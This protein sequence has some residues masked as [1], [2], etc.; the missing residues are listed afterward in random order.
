M[1]DEVS[2]NTDALMRLCAQYDTERRRTVDFCNR[3][4]DLELLT[5]LRAAY[6]PE[7][8]SEAEP[9]AEY[10]GIDIDRFNALSKDDVF[11]L[12]KVGHLSAS[13]LQLYS[14]EN[15]RHLM[16]RRELQSQRAA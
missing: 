9:L 14:L 13:Y 12:H 5:P 8:A 4:R 2:E 7:G 11:D 6:T 10:I 1:G 16:A 15:W 3:L